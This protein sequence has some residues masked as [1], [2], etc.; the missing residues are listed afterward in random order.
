L[1]HLIAYFLCNISA[2]Y[3]ENPTLLSRVIAKTSGMFFETQYIRKHAF[4]TQP[5]RNLDS[6]L[7][8]QCF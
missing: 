1:H 8:D 7:K 6:V 3:Y 5:R 4:S 2:K